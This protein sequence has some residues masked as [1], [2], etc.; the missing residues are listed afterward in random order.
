MA[1]RG[2]Q[3][4]HIQ[5]WNGGI[6]LNI[7]INSVNTPFLNEA[8]EKEPFTEESMY[9]FVD[10]YGDTQIKA[11]AFD[12][13]CQYSATPSKI[14]TDSIALH[15]RRTENGVEVHYDRYE[16]KG[17]YQWYA[18]GIDP[19][20]VWFRRCRQRGMEAW[21]SVRMNDCH[22]PDE[23]ACFL[24]SDFFYEARE[25]GWMVGDA[26]GYYRYCFDYAVPEVR[27]RML[28]YIAEQLDRY[29]VD[30]LEMDFMR[31]I[32]C[33]DYQNC[34]DKVEIMNGFMR[35]AARIAAAAGEKWGHTIKRIVRLPREI[36]QCLVYGFDPETWV[37]EG[38]VDHIN[39]TPRWETCDN[40]MPIAYWKEKIP[41]A[42]ISAGIETLC[43][44]N[45]SG[46][47]QADADV[48]NGLAA[49]YISQGADAVYLYNY[50]MNPYGRTNLHK[51]NVSEFRKRTDTVIRRC[52]SGK[53]VFSSPRRH[54]I[55]F[56]DIAPAGYDRIKPLPMKTE[57]GGKREISLP[58]GYAAPSSQARLIL[59]F[60]TGSPE[61][62]RISVNGTECRNWESCTVPAL[63]TDYTPTDDGYAGSYVKL[64]GCD[65]P[66]EKKD[67]YCISLE[68]QEEAVLDYVEV[69]IC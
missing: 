58:V 33:F 46:L 30:G 68:T 69:Q 43:L 19:Y 57:A 34:P 63:T 36:D 22:C 51:T 24:R 17:I 35:E 9:P 39:V 55:T 11:L 41:G 18:H 44:R 60:S 50:Y 59:G 27:R 65:I 16:Y 23:T 12:V 40:D 8:A 49:A 52:G 53:T 45:D 67:R 64:Y 29:D 47:T 61:T 10:Q 37:K 28:D 7:D 5:N 54:I 38:L 20:D 26:Y 6:I 31:E 32:I 3:R 13:F 56:Q 2:R 66:A 21:L 48:V 62:M 15:D 1:F 25:K 4:M 14:W 42:E